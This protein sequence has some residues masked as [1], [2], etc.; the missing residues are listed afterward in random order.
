MGM[1]FRGREA[2]RLRGVSSS[3]NLVTSSSR[4]QYVICKL[5]LLIY[6]FH[7]SR[8]LDRLNFSFRFFSPKRIT[9]NSFE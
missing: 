7:N 9:P 6:L 5:I 4:F 1:E 8:K 3:R 2:A